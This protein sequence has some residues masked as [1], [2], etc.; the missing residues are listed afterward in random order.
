MGE[1]VPILD[2]QGKTRSPEHQQSVLTGTE[3]MH[4]PWSQAT[5]MGRARFF[6][7]ASGPLLHPKQVGARIA[8]H[9]QEWCLRWAVCH[10]S[11]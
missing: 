10:L 9:A 1:V 5:R 2:R 11:W 6:V 3:R 7:A 8:Q 4:Q